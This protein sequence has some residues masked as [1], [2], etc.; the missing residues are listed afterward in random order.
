MTQY[1]TGVLLNCGALTPQVDFQDTAN[2][3]SVT[4]IHYQ[5]TQNELALLQPAIPE[6]IKAIESAA[7]DAGISTQT[8]SKLQT[9]D[10]SVTGGHWYVKPFLDPK[11]HVVVHKSKH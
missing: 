8:I 9:V 7:T 6:A 11:H 5:S 4:R 3:L 10:N 2:T 1:K